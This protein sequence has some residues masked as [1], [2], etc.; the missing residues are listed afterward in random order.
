MT[1]QCLVNH[2]CRSKM[3]ENLK[4][5]DVTADLVIINRDLFLSLNFKVMP[6]T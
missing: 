3:N 5:F 2:S 1:H 6:P 4:L